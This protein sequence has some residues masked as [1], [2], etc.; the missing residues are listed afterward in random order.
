VPA[1]AGHTVA[2]D[3]NEPAD[4]TWILEHREPDVGMRDE[5]HD[6]VAALAAALSGTPTQ[7]R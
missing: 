1:N 5:I 2:I 3:C 4:E 7:S 6:R